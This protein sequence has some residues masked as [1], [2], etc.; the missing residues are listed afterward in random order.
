MCVCT[1]A[2]VRAC[3]IL[4]S[5]LIQAAINTRVSSTI[6]NLDLTTEILAKT[7]VPGETP[8]MITT[9]KLDITAM[10]EFSDVYT[11]MCSLWISASWSLPIV[12]ML[13]RVGILLLYSD[14]VLLGVANTGGGTS[15]TMGAPGDLFE[16]TNDTQSVVSTMVRTHCSMLQM[17]FIHSMII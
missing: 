13:I 8:E 12:S 14:F 5:V 15:M 17:S 3:A 16:P 1:R 7:V 2:R 10:K 4:L 9:P 6:E 11:G